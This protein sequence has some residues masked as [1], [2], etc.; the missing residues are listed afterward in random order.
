MGWSK[1][2]VASLATLG[3]LGVLAGPA[4]AQEKP[5]L[6]R[7]AGVARLRL[8]LEEGGIR[9][10]TRDKAPPPAAEKA[11]G[12]SEEIVAYLSLPDVKGLL[13]PFVTHGTWQPE[14]WHRGTRDIV[15]GPISFTRLLESRALEPTTRALQI[16]DW[17][18]SNRDDKD[19]ARWPIRVRAY[20]EDR[21]SR[22]EIEWA[23]EIL[24]ELGP[25]MVRL[26]LLAP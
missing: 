15:A 22:A 25:D 1:K 12:V 19:R 6:K 26:G 9:I 14:R 23:Q 24:R 3:V 18:A 21:A 13:K 17:I 10:V 11:R 5:D 8:A 7:L 16:L 20:H 4:K 2:A